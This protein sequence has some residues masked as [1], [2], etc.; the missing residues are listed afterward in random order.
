MV[1]IWNAVRGIGLSPRAE[2]LAG[3]K[4]WART[5]GCWYAGS[6]V[7]HFLAM[8]CLL[9][10]PMKLITADRGEG[11]S[12]TTPATEPAELPDLKDFHLGEAPLETSEL[13]S[14]VLVMRPAAQTEIYYDASEVFRKA[15]GGT[16]QES[17][18]PNLG[19]LGGFSVAA[20]GRGT[21]VLGLGGV[22]AGIGTGTHPGSGGP[23]DGFG[24]RDPSGHRL[25]MI[26]GSATKQGDL[27][28][29]AALNWFY[30]HQES[31]GSWSLSHFAHHCKG[32]ECRGASN[33]RADAGATALALLCFLAAGQTH[34]TDGP[35][36]DA[37]QRAVFWL[38]KRQ[39]S[40][41][42]LSA[43]AEQ[44]M[45]SHGLATIALCEAYGM[46]KDPKVGNPAQ[47]AVGYIER[48]QNRD[49]GSWRYDFQ[50]QD[51]DTSVFGWQVMALKSAQMAGLA[52]SSFNLDHCKFWLA[53][54]AKGEHHGL[55]AY[56]P[57]REYTTS[58]TA[59]GLLCRQYLVRR[60][61]RGG[62]PR[63]QGVP[64]H[65]SA[66]KLRQRPARHL[67]LVL[68]HAGD[69]QPGRAGVG[70]VEPRHAAHAHRKP[71]Q[72][73]LRDGQLGP[74]TP[75]PGQL[76]R[77]GRPD[78]HHRHVDADAGSLLSLPAAV[79]AARRASAHAGRRA[80]TAAG[81]GPKS[82][83]VGP[84]RYA[85]GAQPRHRPVS[86]GTGDVRTWK[87]TAG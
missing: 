40:D 70:P 30:R 69:V 15:G 82:G 23:E 49:A 45:Y 41:G 20:W 10:V 68:R 72:R 58:M 79:S 3:L 44:P 78:R 31:G 13:N 35:Y 12:F 16:K 39:T 17:K 37:V 29:A 51:G 36:R 22:G 53:R 5:E 42:D 63:G 55:F 11:L 73:R 83:P 7:L 33:I 56:Q 26:G 59:V 86:V 28:I 9:L 54:V 21:H 62:H 75:R 14:Q 67:L 76:E 61:R 85:A 65:P 46:T 47:A 19:G 48:A 2:M 32:R 25:A 74:G 34:K 18:E 52:V 64:P 57:Y 87:T 60:A 84:C 43:G 81:G 71:V 50:S 38:I 8:L 1:R 80:G 24:N 6:A 66:G 4:D 77:K 27:A